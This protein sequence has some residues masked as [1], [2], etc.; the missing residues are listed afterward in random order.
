MNSSEGSRFTKVDNSNLSSS[1][2]SASSTSFPGAFIDTVHSSSGTSPF[3]F[4][5]DNSKLGMNKDL[6]E[7]DIVANMAPLGTNNSEN[8]IHSSYAPLG[9]DKNNKPPTTQ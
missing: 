7:V 2:S 6:L 5:S 4:G 8:S 9:I 1:S 3:P